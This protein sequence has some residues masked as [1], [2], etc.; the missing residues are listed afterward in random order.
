M[1]PLAAGWPD[2]PCSQTRSRP[3][4]VFPPGPLLICHRLICAVTVLTPSPRVKTNT[5]TEKT[6]LRESIEPVSNQVRDP[7]PYL[8]H[9][10]L[11]AP[12]FHEQMQGCE[13]AFAFAGMLGVIQWC[14]DQTMP[15]ERT[16]SARV[17]RRSIAHLFLFDGVRTEWLAHTTE[18]PAHYAQ[19]LW[20][21]AGSLSSTARR[22]W[23]SWGVDC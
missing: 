4:C 10:H 3:H 12:F 6:K 13:E 22:S 8:T 16:A 18:Q 2:W 19:A 1:P 20:C 17:V 21:E 23:F 14:L 5:C 9:A 11:F 7:P 15:S